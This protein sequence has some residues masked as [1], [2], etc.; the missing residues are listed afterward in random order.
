MAAR[1]QTLMRVLL[2]LVFIALSA[3]AEV[4]MSV[5]QLKSFIESSGKLGHTD[6]QVAAYLKNVKLTQRLSPGVIEDIQAAGA[7]AKTLEALRSL[8]E[9]TQNLP[10][11]PP[12][13]PKPVVQPIPP[14]DSLE[15]G[16]VLE[17]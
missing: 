3:G 16:R 8:G 17:Q 9:Q 13:A 4:R 2:G 6:R 1:V 11:P 5:A 12:P 14:P 10:A 15:Q 7:G